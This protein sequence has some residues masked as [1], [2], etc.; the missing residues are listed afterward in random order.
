MTNI[1]AAI[2]LAQ[3]ETLG[4]TLFKKNKIAEY[5]RENLA[6]LPIEFQETGRD[7]ISSSWMFSI[8]VKDFEKRESIR[9]YL[10][11]KFIETRPIFYPVHTMPIYC[12]QFN[13]FPVAENLGV[14]GINLPSWPDLT[15]E[16]LEYINSCIHEFFED[17]K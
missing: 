3:L 13:H 2:G 10:E 9:S 14:R 17:Y 8:L 7:V 4:N 6:S 16:N 5:Y 1:C 11:A 12:D 15:H